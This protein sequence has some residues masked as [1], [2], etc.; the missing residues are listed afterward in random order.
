MFEELIRQTNAT[1]PRE[2]GYVYVNY[3]WDTNISTTEPILVLILNFAGD[4]EA[5]APHAEPFKVLHPVSSVEGEV[6]Y[7][8]IAKA[9]GTDVDDAACDRGKE[10]FLHA[11]DLVT[12][13]VSTNRA[14]FELF[15]NMTMTYP[16]YQESAV[17]F[18]SYS[19]QGLKAVDPNSTAFPNR[20]SN[21]IFA[22]TAIYPTNPDLDQRAVEWGEQTR[23]LVHTG[24]GPEVN[25]EVYVNYAYGNETMESLYGYE[26]WRLE[27]LRA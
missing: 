17:M 25:L 7:V 20:G 18:E 15:K 3:M 1:L 11:A 14:I 19:Q 5:A 6:P 23:S 27:K 21:I 4:K 12:Y 9:T 22:L 24:Q 26:P 13:N 2:M 10:Y 8:Q 16:E